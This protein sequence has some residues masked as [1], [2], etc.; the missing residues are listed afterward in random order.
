M[1]SRTPVL[2]GVL[3]LL[4]LASC[5]ERLEDGEFARAVTIEGL[6]GAIGGEAALARPGDFLLESDQL[7]AVVLSGRV[8]MAGGLYGGSLIDV[9]KQ[10]FDPAASGG[11]GRDQF[12]EF[13]PTANLNVQGA[14]LKEDVFIAADGSDGGPAIVRVAAEGAPFLSFLDLLWGLVGMPE[15]WMTT[16]Y[17]VTPGQKW[18]DIK[19][20][21]A[22]QET[23][24]PVVDGTPVQYATGSLDVIG[25]GVE[26]GLVIGDFFLVGGSLDV[27]APGIGFDEDGAVFRAGES[28]R[29]IFSDPF[30]FEFLAGVGDGVS[31]GIAPKEG[32]LFVPLFTG[33]QTVAISGFENGDGSAARFP[34]TDAY[35]YERFFFVGDGDVGSVLDQYIEAR[36]IPYG[37]VTGQ[38][39]EQ[40]TGLPMSGISV[41][42][43]EPGAEYPW[44]QW[45]TDVGVHDQLADA[46]FGGRLPV[47]MWELMVHQSGRTDSPRF[48]LE[49]T[50]G[51]SASVLMEAP[52]PGMLSF[53]ILDERGQRIPSKLT[54]KRVDTTV[55]SNLQPAL[56]DSFIANDPDAVVF[57]ERG[58]GEVPLPP[59]EY[60]AFASRGPEYEIDISD[61]FTIDESRGHRI[62]LQIQRSVDTSGW[63]A[64]DFHVHSAPSFDSGV[65]LRD[66]VRTMVAEGV[67]FF[68]P[69][70]HDHIT[71]IS[72][73]IEDMGLEEFVQAAPGVE[74][75][76]LEMGHFLGFPLQE[77]FLGDNGGAF[78]WTGMPPD[79]IIGGLREAASDAGFEGFVFVA[80]PRD[81]ILGYFDQFGYDPYGGT[82]GEPRWLPGLLTAANPLIDRSNTTMAFDG[83]EVF[84]AKRVD[85]HRTPTAPELS[86]YTARD[87]T[88]VY[89]WISR[90]MEEQQALID[91]TYT[92]G[93][94]LEGMLDDWFTML[95]L[96]L[97][98]TAMGNSDTHSTTTV[99]AGLPRNYVLSETDSPAFLRPQDIADAMRDHRV[100]ASYGPFLRMWIDGE[101]IGGDVVASG[102]TVEVQIE[103]QA[104]TWMSVDRVELYENGT[105]IREWTVADD[106]DP[107]QRMYERFDLE[108]TEDAWYV[109]VTMGEGGMEPVFN[110]VE[111]PYF[112]LDEAVSSAL[113][114]VSVLSSFPLAGPD[115]PKSYPIHPY[116]VTN[117]IWVDADGGGWDAPGLPSWL[118]KP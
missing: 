32:N 118:V 39:L 53:D 75:T 29:V 55:T 4:L 59:G 97:R 11:R 21:V 13:F 36:A 93:A 28:G 64:A 76:T 22:F 77:Q 46:S 95:N 84:T 25:V 103:V 52:R 30:E 89:D 65:T 51:S 90:T 8:N 112:P 100:V 108:V 58:T 115:F 72:P 91:G 78:D 61:V 45:E 60:V 74:A 33:S 14:R 3:P 1:M 10:W 6:S 48:S 15:M 41:F 116:A 16:D 5:G 87:G 68:T 37:E 117:P 107:I 82:P 43:F 7:R 2:A 31:Y 50:E 9:D 12:N 105:L 71:D 80:H 67:E 56:G 19:T 42:V 27:F 44:S 23:D 73:T 35:T 99:E 83:L 111:I 49:V 70:D 38:V 81:G 98:V 110:A 40:G 92:L 24:E 79:D 66:R 54:I 101:N 94:D 62:E 18:I 86:G 109:A 106:A 26:D 85:L 104:P 20:T 114:D 113:G 63:I 88:D 69:T 96:G 102:G 57:A 17:I 47:G 34:A